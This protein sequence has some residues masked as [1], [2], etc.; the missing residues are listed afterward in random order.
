MQKTI[1][2]LFFLS[3]CIFANNNADIEFLIYK[4]TDKEMGLDE[5]KDKLDNFVEIERGETFDDKTLVYWRVLKTHGLLETGEYMVRYGSADFDLVSFSKE[6]LFRKNLFGKDKVF[7][8]FY[9]KNRDE[10]LYY[11]RFLA[12]NEA[13]VND[14]FSIETVEEF[15]AS[16]SDYFYYLLISGILLGLIL[17]TALYNGAVYYYKRNRVFLYYAMMQFFIVSLLLYSTGIVEFSTK[18][19][20]LKLDMLGL[21]YVLFGTLFTASFFDTINILS[22]WDKVLKFCLGFI[23]FDIFYLLFTGFSIISIYNL[24][25]LL[26]LIYLLIGYRRYKDGFKP[27]KFFLIGWGVLVFN[28]FL[29]EYINEHDGMFLLFGSSLEAIFLAIGLAYNIRLLDEEK[30]EQKKMLIHQSKLAS[31]GEMIG[32]IAHQWRQPL[33]YLSYNFMT[34]KEANNQNVLEPKYLNKKLDEATVQV[35]FMS[36]TI[37]DFKDFYAPKKEKELFLLSKATEETLALMKN[38]FVHEKIEVCLKIEED[39]EL[40]NYKNEYKQVLLNLLSNAKD[41]LVQRAI[42]NPKIV[43]AINKNNI[44]ISD[45]AKGIEAKVMNRIFEPYFST[46]EGGLGIGLY[47]SKM[48]IEKNMGAKL[49]VKNDLDGV[50]FEIIF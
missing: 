38:T 14:Y 17:M 37:D 12:Q 25:S 10:S 20:E 26:G 50:V 2:L 3:I 6:Q 8:F 36:Q 27:A 42:K 18:S 1:F 47:M 48:I 21:F 31:M 46:K 13:S 23:I 4:T 32:N 7:R 5:I 45:N 22:R 24:Y 43:I 9:D 11:F 33:T 41:V 49:S 34:L 29:T 19:D 39:L 28:V 16:T 40:E 30:E 35:E 15:Y 44:S